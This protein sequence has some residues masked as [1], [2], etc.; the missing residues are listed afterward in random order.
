[1]IASL[2]GFASN[3]AVTKKAEYWELPI[4]APRMEP[5]VFTAL[6]ACRMLQ[7]G[8]GWRMNDGCEKRAQASCQY[9]A[10]VRNILNTEGSG[11]YFFLHDGPVAWVFKL[12]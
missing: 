11:T 1:M 2:M 7:V 12:R 3:G 6:K 8:Q 5:Q 10:M 4:P 9:R